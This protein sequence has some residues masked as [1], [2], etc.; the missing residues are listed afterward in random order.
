MYSTLCQ[1]ARPRCVEVELPEPQTPARRT[2][3]LKILHVMPTLMLEWGGPVRA[4]IDLAEAMAAHGH[5]VDVAACIDSGCPDAWRGRDR[6]GTFPRLIKYRQGSLPG[7]LFTP[8][9]L[10]RFGPMFERYDVV[11]FHNIWRPSILQLAP[12]AERSGASYIVSTRG[13]LDDWSMAQKRVKKHV[14]LALGGR[15]VLERAGWV[16]CTAEVER[17]QVRRWIGAGRA[18]V[19]PNFMNLRPYVDP[20]G[21]GAARRHFDLPDDGVPLVVFLSRVD[22]KKGVDTLIRSAALL[23]DRGVEHRLVIAG[24]A[25]PAYLRAMRELAGDLGIEG[26]VRFVGMVTGELKQSLLRAARVFALP[27]NQE[28][29]GFVYFEALACGTPVVTTGCVDTAAD[30]AAGGGT[31]LSMPEPEAFSRQVERLLEDEDLADRMGAT[32]RRWVFRYLSP[33]PLISQFEDLYRTANERWPR[34]PDPA[35]YM[36][37]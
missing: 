2:R 37:R 12:L 23:R 25:D 19:V 17:R 4:V 29:F 14:F 27:S 30:L 33:G 36:P 3:G 1:E 21:P 34:I 18:A 31:L 7:P 20:A 10:A 26:A 32:G 8:P 24:N 13:M 22:P 6:G 28:N 5:E 16:H 9:E 11:H 35:P 15:R